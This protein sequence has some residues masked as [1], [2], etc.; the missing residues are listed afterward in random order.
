MMF[1]L[2]TITTVMNMMIGYLFPR[3]VVG[4]LTR[5]QSHSPSENGN[6]C[7]K[8]IPMGKKR[9]LVSSVNTRICLGNV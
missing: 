7:S 4:K 1:L 3:F 9:F 6:I 8:N 5:L 2:I